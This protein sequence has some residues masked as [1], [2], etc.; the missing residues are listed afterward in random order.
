MKQTNKEYNWIVQKSEKQ[1][2]WLQIYDKKNHKI[3][4]IRKKI[5]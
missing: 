3:S 2:F 4:W 1:F 5:K